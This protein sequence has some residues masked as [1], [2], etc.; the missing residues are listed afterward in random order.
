ML[1]WS[2]GQHACLKDSFDKWNIIQRTL[3]YLSYLLFT[4][5]LILDI[6]SF[7]FSNHTSYNPFVAHSLNLRVKCIVSVPKVVCLCHSSTWT[8]KTYFHV[9]KLIKVPKSPQLLWDPTWRSRGMPV[10]TH[11]LS[12]FLFLSSFPFMWGKN[13]RRETK[14]GRKKKKKKKKTRISIWHV[15]LVFMWHAR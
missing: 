15:T 12:L 2:S 14:K 11:F 4:P 1:R 3:L 7:S 9:S 10:L 5:H 6:H 13:D 8:L